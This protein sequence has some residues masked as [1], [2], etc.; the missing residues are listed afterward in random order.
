MNEYSIRL[1]KPHCD[2]CHKPKKQETIITAISNN[3]SLSS[4]LQQAIQRANQ[5]KEEEGE[6]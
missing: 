4:K 6:I 3:S 1:A 5:P 2:N